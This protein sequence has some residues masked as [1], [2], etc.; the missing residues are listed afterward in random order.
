VTPMEEDEVLGVVRHSFECDLGVC[1]GRHNVNH[2][3]TEECSASTSGRER[4]DS[5]SGS[6]DGTLNSAL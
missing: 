1:G 5:P 4:I 2:M 3:H 6:S